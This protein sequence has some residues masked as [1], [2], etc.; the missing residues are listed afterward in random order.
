MNILYEGY[1]LTQVYHGITALSLP[2][3]VLHKGEVLGL[4]GPNGS[5]KST[6][7]RLLA[8]LEPPA[9]GKLLW[10][11]GEDAPRREITLLLQEPYLLRDNVFRNVTLGLALRGKKKA[12]YDAYTA[13]MRAVGFDKADDMAKR[14]S[15]ALSGGEKQRVAL[16]ARLIL[17]PTV[18]LLDEPTSSVDALSARAIVH[19]VRETIA[20]G[21][22]VVYATHDKNLQNALGGRILQ[23]GT[24]ISF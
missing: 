9:S 12:L 15:H 11:G 6:L 14:P 16:A 24:G 17:H 13:A 20:E 19:A 4:T 1:D 21:T 22:T 8:F 3:F 7:L 18:L 5:G 23:I 2:K 10:Q